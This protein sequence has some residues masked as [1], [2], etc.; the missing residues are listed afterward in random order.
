[1]CSSTQNCGEYF[2]FFFHIFNSIIFPVVCFQGKLVFLSTALSRMAPR[3]KKT[4]EAAK[5]KSLDPTV[6][7]STIH[8]HKVLHGISYKNRAP[9]CVDGRGGRRPPLGGA[10]GRAAR[11]A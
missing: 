10:R 6:R 9:R 4:K 1:M 2:I 7:E 11:R 8:L 3:T 5:S